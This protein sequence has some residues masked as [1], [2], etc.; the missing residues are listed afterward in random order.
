L[1]HRDA[2]SIAVIIATNVATIIPA[3]ADMADTHRLTVRRRWGGR[4]H[5]SPDDPEH[6]EFRRERWCSIGKT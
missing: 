2:V 5:Q 4:R 1:V 6:T 3:T